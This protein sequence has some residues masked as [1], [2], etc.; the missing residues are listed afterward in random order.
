MYLQTNKKVV[1]EEGLDREML[2]I[3]SGLNK[4]KQ[5]FELWPSSEEH[6][7]RNSGTRM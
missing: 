5:V 3:K 1:G 6:R 7:D 2:E 4:I